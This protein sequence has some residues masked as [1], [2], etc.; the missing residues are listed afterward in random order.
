MTTKLLTFVFSNGEKSKHFYKREQG[1]IYATVKTAAGKEYNPPKWSRVHAPELFEESF[2][3][4]V[5][6]KKRGVK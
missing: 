1:M 3:Q 2:G 4:F 6:V 5:E